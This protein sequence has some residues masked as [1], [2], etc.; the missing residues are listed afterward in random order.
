[1]RYP[2]PTDLKMAPAWENYAVAQLTQAGLGRIPSTALALGVEIHGTYLRV[3]AQ[4]SDPSRSDLD[5]I[6]DIQSSLEDLVG[7]DVQ[8]ELVVEHRDERNVS[9]IDGVRWVYLRALGA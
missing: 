3:V 8:V 2:S 4:V 9:P 1:M 6:G 7:P 5:D